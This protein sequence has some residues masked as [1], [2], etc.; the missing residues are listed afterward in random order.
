MLFLNNFIVFLSDVTI[1]NIMSL[2]LQNFDF[3]S[4]SLNCRVNIIS[5]NKDLENWCCL[6]IFWTIYR[7]EKEKNMLQR[8]FIFL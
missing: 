5:N 1:N 4:G 2:C 6:P 7:S 3:R 8:L